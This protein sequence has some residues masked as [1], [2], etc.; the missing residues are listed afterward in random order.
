MGYNADIPL[1]KKPAFAI[2]DIA[3]EETRNERWRA[4]VEL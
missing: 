2:Y 3:E 4:N 1:E